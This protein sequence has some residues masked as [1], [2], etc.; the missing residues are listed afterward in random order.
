MWKIT[1]CQGNQIKPTRQGKFKVFVRE[2]LGTDLTTQD[3]L[4]R[5]T[6]FKN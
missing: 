6:E 4:L 5:Y 2:T 3:S 1:P